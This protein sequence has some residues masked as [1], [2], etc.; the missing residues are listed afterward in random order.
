MCQVGY[1][2]ELHR[3]ARSLE[4]KKVRRIV[5]FTATTKIQVYR[6]RKWVGCVP[7]YAILRHLH[8]LCSCRSGND[9]TRQKVGFRHGKA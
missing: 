8:G 2:L 9:W 6:T 3:D 4:Y 7:E 5:T 1:L